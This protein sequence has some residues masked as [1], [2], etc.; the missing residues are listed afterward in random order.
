[1]HILKNQC[2]GFF[3]KKVYKLSQSLKHADLYFEDF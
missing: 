1:M 2:S 3:K